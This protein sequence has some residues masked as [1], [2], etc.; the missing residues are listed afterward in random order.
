[1]LNQIWASSI[2]LNISKNIWLGFPKPDIQI[3][4]NAPL[5]KQDQE[6]SKELSL[7]RLL[8]K[9]NKSNS[10]LYILYLKVSIDKANAV[11]KS[12]NYNCTK[13]SIIV[14]IY[15]SL[16]LTFSAPNRPNLSK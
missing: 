5:S 3:S 9:I 14:V 1:M 8:K 15:Q 2:V 11:F 4:G 13:L 16:D 6:D 7:F 10:F 12:K